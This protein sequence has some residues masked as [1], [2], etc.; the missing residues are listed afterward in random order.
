MSR[1]QAECV[2]NLGG[3]RIAHLPREIEV[4]GKALCES[5]ELMTD[6]EN[7]LDCVCHP[8]DSPDTPKDARPE[9]VIASRA[10][11]IRFHR[12]ALDR[13]NQRI[14]ALLSRLEV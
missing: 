8:D 12:Y 2:T 11:D 5:Q 13:I 1:V 6:L 7:R 3:N 4:L 14:R 10:Q 9:E